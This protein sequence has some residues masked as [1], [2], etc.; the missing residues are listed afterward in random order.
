MR[1]HEAN[2]TGL[3]S[4]VVFMGIGTYALVAGPD[5]VADAMRWMWPVTLLGLGLA[6]LIGSSGREHRAGDEVRAESGEDREVEQS[7]GGH[8]GG[9]GTLL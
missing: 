4:G 6:L 9:V 2:L 1:R 5:R 8:D 7:G 3:L